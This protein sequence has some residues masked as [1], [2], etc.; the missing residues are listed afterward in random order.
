ML[1]FISQEV[2]ICRGT[3]L[4]LSNNSPS[5]I[6][7]PNS[8]EKVLEIKVNLQ[9]PSSEILR[10][11]ATEDSDCIAEKRESLYSGL[12][13]NP[14][15]K[16]K[17]LAFPL[18]LNI[19]NSQSLITPKKKE[20]RLTMSRDPFA[21]PDKPEKRKAMHQTFKSQNV[22]S[23]FLRTSLQPPQKNHNFTYFIQSEQKPAHNTTNSF[24]KKSTSLREEK[25]KRALKILEK[26]LSGPNNH[27]NITGQ[28]HRTSCSFE[29]P[30]IKEFYKGINFPEDKAASKNTSR[31]SQGVGGKANLVY[32]LQAKINIHSKAKLDRKYATGVFSKIEENFDSEDLSEGISGELSGIY[33]YFFRRERLVLNKIL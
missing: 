11:N 19:E 7:T 21:S 29:S 18:Q 8:R 4:P 23:P 9:N 13:I 10:E 32:Y 31:I 20:E 12:Q 17:S 28:I 25:P 26:S 14:R 22:V 16:N 5:L 3:T 2:S 1:P 24:L 33:A 15:N 6:D 27:L 30:D